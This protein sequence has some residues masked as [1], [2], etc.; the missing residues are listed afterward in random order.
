MKMNKKVG[1]R[2]LAL[3]LTVGLIFMVSA[4][5]GPEIPEDD[6]TRASVEIHI[7]RIHYDKFGNILHVDH[8]PGNLTDLGA[9]WIAD[10]LGD[11]DGDQADFIG[12]T[13]SVTAYADAW[14][15]LPTEITTGGLARA[16][17]TYVDDGVGA[18]NIT[19]TFSVTGT[20]SCRRAG[21]YLQ[22]SGDNLVATDEFAVTNVENGDSLQII[23]SISV[24][25]V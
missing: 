2:T 23:F 12:L 10:V 1:W 11:A 6:G 5:M 3:A 22:V 20:E 21:L 15:V 14:I 7:T 8:H 16:Q 24:S 9:D 25:D 18:W 19:Y 4:F 17:G 13:D